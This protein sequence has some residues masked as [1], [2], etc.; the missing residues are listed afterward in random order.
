MLLV[1]ERTRVCQIRH[2]VQPQ[3]AQKCVRCM[4]ARLGQLQ[5]AIV[6]I[7]CVF[8]FRAQAAI[9]AEAIPCKGYLKLNYVVGA[10]KCVVRT[11]PSSCS[12]KS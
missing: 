1:A 4:A 8:P 9:Y 7:S 10:A 2:Q 12:A 6:S 5:G 3:V 11:L